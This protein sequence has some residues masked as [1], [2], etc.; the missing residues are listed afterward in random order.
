MDEIACA[1]QE[2]EPCSIH[3]NVAMVS[4]KESALADVLLD[5]LLITVVLQLDTTGGLTLHYQKD[6]VDD[7]EIYQREDPARVVCADLF[8]F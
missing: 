5:L 3:D 6:R 2:S 4:H 1:E 8:E 7:K